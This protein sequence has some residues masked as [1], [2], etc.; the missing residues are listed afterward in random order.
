MAGFTTA[1]RLAWP[2]V[3]SA[4]TTV[5]VLL[6]RAAWRSGDSAVAASVRGALGVVVLLVFG[7]Y[8]VKVRDRLHQRIR[9]FMDEGRSHT[10]QQRS[11]A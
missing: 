9:K 4:L 6:P 3:V 1:I 7:A 5:T 11:S 10:A 2:I 8:W